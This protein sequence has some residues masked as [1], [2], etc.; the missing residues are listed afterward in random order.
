VVTG[1]D[2][3]PSAQ[4]QDSHPG[5]LS[6]RE[7][8][9]TLTSSPLTGLAGTFPVT[10]ETTDSF[11]VAGGQTAPT[12]GWLRGNYTLRLSAPP[13]ANCGPAVATVPIQVT[14]GVIY[15]SPVNAVVGVAYNNTIA[16]ARIP[17]TPPASVTI[18][19]GDNTTSNGSLSAVSGQQGVYQILASHTYCGG[20]L[21]GTSKCHL[22]QTAI[23]GSLLSNFNITVLVSKKLGSISV[24]GTLEVDPQHPDAEY[25]IVPVAPLQKEPTLFWPKPAAKNQSPIS[26]YDWTFLDTPFHVIDDGGTN[27]ATIRL[28]AVGL[29]LKPSNPCPLSIDQLITNLYGPA[30]LSTDPGSLISQFKANGNN[31]NNPQWRDCGVVLGILPI[32]QGA[33]PFGI[34]SMNDQDIQGFAKD[35]FDLFETN[36]SQGVP[37]HVVPHW[38]DES[39]NVGVG[40]TVS[41]TVSGKTWTS[42]EYKNNW[43]IGPNVCGGLLGMPIIGLVSYGACDIAT[44]IGTINT[45]ENDPRPADY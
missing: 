38:F 22:G 16:L 24:T 36:D 17:S 18:S 21:S 13:T 12:T 23:N 9:V 44:A 28:V 11:G 45:I 40:L 33:G 39:G 42:S 19:W 25:K 6:G 37:Q 26:K 32:D 34:G 14:L 31:E 7:I 5:C 1:T 27:S 4:L 35:W 3:T 43:T 41:G 29:M 30:A 15:P 20:D 8:D 10:T 2:A